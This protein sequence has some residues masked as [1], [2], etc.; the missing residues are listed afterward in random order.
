MLSVA[1]DYDADHD[2]LDISFGDHDGLTHEFQL[3]DHVT[4]TTD[5]TLS[6]VV[7]VGLREY[8]RMLLVSETEFTNLRDEDPDTVEE[9]LYLMTVPPLSRLFDLTD[10][11]ALVARVCA[12]TISQLVDDGGD[13]RAPWR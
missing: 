8:V 4:V 1:L 13:G 9:L 5:T 3:N 11:E 6:R 7:H 2:W 10:P 12:P